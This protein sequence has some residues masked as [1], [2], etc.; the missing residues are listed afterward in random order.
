MDMIWINSWSDNDLPGVW[1]AI[2]TDGVTFTGH[3]SENNVIDMRK[4]QK[5]LTIQ[6]FNQRIKIRRHL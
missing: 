5:S 2:E 3:D 4:Y 6:L 1:Y